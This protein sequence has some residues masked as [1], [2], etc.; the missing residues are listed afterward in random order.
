MSW[1]CRSTDK[2]SNA[3]GDHLE[4]REDNGRITLTS[5][6]GKYVVSGTGSWCAVAVLNLRNSRDT[7]LKLTPQKAT[8][9]FLNRKERHFSES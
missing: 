8:A 6:L 7:L 9:L 4:D 5:V 3:E 1:T 2:A